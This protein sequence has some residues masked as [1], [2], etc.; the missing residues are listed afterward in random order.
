MP[1]ETQRL[2]LEG[3]KVLDFGRVIAGPFVGQVLSDLGAD[4]I[5]IERPPAGDE[6]RSY[7]SGDKPGNST[8]FSTLNRNK[9]SLVIDLTNP[10]AT[11]VIAK[12]V[13]GADVLVHN[14]RA[15]VMERRGLS[16][17]DAWKLN[18]RLT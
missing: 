6:T 15:G 1:G 5:K 3:I 10:S 13:A 17:E 9:R 2:P 14:F 18:P 4:V 8:P 12:L 16:P 7:S 11:P